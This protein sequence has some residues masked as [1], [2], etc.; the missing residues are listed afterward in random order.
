MPRDDATLLDI[1]A[2]A[3]L[4]AEFTEG[5][6]EG[7]FI[8]DTRTI[9]AVLH[10]ITVIG[11]ATKRLSPGFRERHPGTPWHLIAGM[12]DKLI[13]EYDD[14]DLE[15]VWKTATTDVPDL[16]AYVEPLLPS[17]ASDIVL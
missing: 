11:E 3:R 15:E 6:D 10:Q 4:V 16:L 1:A 7:G 12:R 17:S 5:V 13:H 8:R 2:A 9:S 14:V